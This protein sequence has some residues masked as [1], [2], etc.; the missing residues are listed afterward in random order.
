M[1][2]V[3][4]RRRPSIDPSRNTGLV[5]VESW[6]ISTRL[7]HDA[8]SIPHRTDA[9]EG[10]AFGHQLLEATREPRRGGVGGV[11]VT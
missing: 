10:E 8:I 5:R 9:G 7:P 4:T 1:P 11:D 2:I 6:R 3:N